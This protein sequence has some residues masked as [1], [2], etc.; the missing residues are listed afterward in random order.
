[1]VVW[2]LSALGSLGWMGAGCS[3]PHGSRDMALISAPAARG[4]CW[5]LGPSG[6]AAG[7][8]RSCE[9]EELEEVLIYPA[10]YPCG[11]AGHST[12]RRS[13]PAPRGGSEP[14]TLPLI[15]GTPSLQPE[16]DA[17]PNCNAGKRP[18]LGQGVSQRLAKLK[19]DVFSR[20]VPGNQPRTNCGPGEMSPPPPKAQTEHPVR[21]PT[22]T[23]HLHT[24]RQGC[25]L[26]TGTRLRS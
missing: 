19:H 12:G 21:I 24:L 23:A 9:W 5:L 18:P 2:L 7:K 17:N 25:I 4:G 6:R 8:G 13:Q 1:M 15:P 10:E 16:R 3:Q 26:A 20:M 11:R 22:D 14:P